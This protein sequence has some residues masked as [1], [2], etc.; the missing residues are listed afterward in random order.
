MTEPTL[1]HVRRY[2]LPW[3]DP[4]LTRTECGRFPKEFAE[5]LTHE[6]LGALVKDL[7][8]QRASMQVCMTCWSRSSVYY[9]LRESWDANPEQVIAREAESGGRGREENPLR[10]ELRAIAALIESH[11]DE[12]RDLLRGLDEMVSAEALAARRAEKRYRAEPHRSRL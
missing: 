8:Q 10:R 7:G 2:R 5:V 6:E 9:A 12:F 1:A 3:R 11:P 4:A